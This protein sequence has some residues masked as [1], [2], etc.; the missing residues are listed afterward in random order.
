VYMCQKLLIWVDTIDKVIVT[1]SRLT[2][3]WPTL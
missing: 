1:I 2:F 3:Y